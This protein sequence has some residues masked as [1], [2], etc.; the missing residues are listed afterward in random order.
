MHGTVLPH[1]CPPDGALR[2]FRAFDGANP[3]LLTV[4]FMIVDEE[5]FEFG[6]K[7]FSE[8]IYLLDASEAVVGIFNSHRVRID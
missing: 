6:A 4:Q 5:L 7:G 3:I 8:I 2:C 1:A